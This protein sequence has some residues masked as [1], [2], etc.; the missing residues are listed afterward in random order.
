MPGP[1]YNWLCVAHSVLDVLSNAAAIRASQVYPRT[2]SAAVRR[3]LERGT[4]RPVNLNELD[5]E[6]FNPFVGKS[7]LN[8]LD[9]MGDAHIGMYKVSTRFWYSSNPVGTSS[10]SERTVQWPSNAPPEC[11]RTPPFPKNISRLRV[12]EFMFTEPRIPET[13]PEPIFAK[14]TSP[15]ASLAVNSLTDHPSTTLEGPQTSPPEAGV[16]RSMPPS[17]VRQLTSSKIP[18]SRIGRLFHYGG[19]PLHPWPGYQ[20]SDIPTGLAASLGY[21]AA[22]EIL[23]RSVSGEESSQNGGSLMLTESNVKRLVTKLTKM[24]GAALKLGQFMSIQGKRPRD[25][26]SVRNLPSPTLRYAPSAA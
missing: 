20:L 11:A 24:R 13:P 9:E 26:P 3:D 15:G 8:A 4:A 16:L 2:A 6:K 25:F 10:M 17:E 14:E 23:R 12:Q 5:D 21:G 22:S 1:I 19:K 18:S 7:S